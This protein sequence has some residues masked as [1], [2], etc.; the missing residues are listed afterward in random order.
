M[1]GGL[2]GDGGS[3]K[4]FQTPLN[5]SKLNGKP[6]PGHVVPKA[7]RI[8]LESVLRAFKCVYRYCS[9]GHVASL[10]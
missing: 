7:R 2:G 8:A 10:A 5:R 9:P 3:L 6:P 4:G 1:G